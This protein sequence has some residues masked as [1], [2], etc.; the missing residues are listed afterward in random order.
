M[1][2][3][4]LHRFFLFKTTIFLKYK[5]HL[6]KI[7]SRWSEGVL[8]L[9]FR[10]SSFHLHNSGSKRRNATKGKLG[11][12]SYSLIWWSRKSELFASAVPHH[13]MRFFIFQQLANNL[14]H[15]LPSGYAEAHLGMLYEQQLKT[16]FRI[17]TDRKL[18][19]EKCSKAKSYMESFLTG[20]VHWHT[21]C[22]VKSII[23]PVNHID[24]FL[25]AS[26]W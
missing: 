2:V 24:L 21:G 25:S 10:G 20:F 4:E 17:N 9:S 5:N 16:Y 7:G 26:F 12:L 1:R 11:P 22:S 15:L 6:T 19:M 8:K 3:Y 23:A 13:A 14:T 18:P